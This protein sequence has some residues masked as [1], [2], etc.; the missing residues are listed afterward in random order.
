MSSATGRHEDAVAVQAP[1]SRALVLGLGDSGLAMARW[2]AARG[3][4]LRV[5]DTRGEPPG[6]AALAAACPAAEFVGGEF[7]PA[8]LDGVELV[9]ISPGLAPT[10]PGVALLLKHAKSSKVEV[11]GELELFARELARLKAQRGYAPKV[12]GITGT[13]GK[14]TTTRLTGLLLERSGVRVAVAGNIAPA[15][16]DVLRDTLANDT[17][18]DAWVLELSSFQLVTARSLECDAAAVLNVT[19]DHLDWHGTMEAY[20][21]AKARIFSAKTVQVLNRDDERVMAMARSNAE[22]VT[23]GSDAPAAGNAYGLVLD[24]G[25]TWLAWAEDLS[26]SGRRRKAN[27]ETPAA[28]AEIHLHRLMPTD[29]LQIRGRHNALNALAAIALARAAGCQLGPLL[30]AM[31]SYRGEPHRVETIATV[32][33]VEYVDDS[34][35][36][37]VGATVAALDGLGAEGRKLV[38]ILGGDGKGQDFSP[39]VG[40]VVRHARAVVLIGRDAPA[41]RAVLEQAAAHV[42]M[43]LSD[44]L[45]AA[46]EAASAA[47]RPG[48]AVLLSPACA[49]L[50]M[51]RNYVHR[52]EVFAEAVR[53][54]AAEAG[55]PC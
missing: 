30:H 1:A 13:N 23:F 29:A 20:A 31:R 16:L 2:L 18:P 49:S 4:G 22:V 38:V 47:A 12:I 43:H 42:P 45:P 17:L 25:M 44:S 21:A 10:N 5:A 41:I 40:P 51:F 33:G 9:A 34:K 37:N 36:T 8:L 35:G 7:T 11:V 52:S 50:D 32:G 27:A 48:D 54:L 24:N 6:R 46:V 14:T 15:A 53:E 19:Q 55:Q 39:L 28:P 3:F 26:P